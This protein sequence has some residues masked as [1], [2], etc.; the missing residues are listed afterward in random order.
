V[1]VTFTVPLPAGATAV[2][3]LAEL[4]VKLLAALAPNFTAL[5]PVKL[6]PVMLTVVPPVSGPVLG[7]KL[8]TVGA[9]GGGGGGGGGA[10]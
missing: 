3:A 4:T 1:T 10:A 2:I 5:A 9:G 6:V 7:L 8:A